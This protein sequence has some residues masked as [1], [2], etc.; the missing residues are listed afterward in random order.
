MLGTPDRGTIG[1]KTPGG[2]TI[3]D[4]GTPDGCTM[5]LEVLEGL[6]Y[7][8]RGGKSVLVE[9]PD[10]CKLFSLIFMPGN[11]LEKTLEMFLLITATPRNLFKCF[12]SKKNDCFA[13]FECLTKWNFAET[14]AP[15]KIELT[16]VPFILNSSL[17]GKISERIIFAVGNFSNALLDIS[18]SL[19]AIIL[20]SILSFSRSL[21][22]VCIRIAS[23][24]LNLG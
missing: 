11:K 15:A 12:L 14:E 21:V 16:S 22:P 6:S 17:R 10:C 13:K 9:Y 3:V 7:L 18:I 8:S 2:G 5:D 20:E 23:T 19:L 24:S 1:D 4:I